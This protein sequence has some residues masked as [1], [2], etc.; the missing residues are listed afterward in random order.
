MRMVKCWNQVTQ[1]GGTCPIAGNIQGQVGWALSSLVELE[2]SLLIAGGLDYMT[3]KGPFQPRLFY[4]SMI[5][6]S[7]KL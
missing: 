7:K 6:D 5:L 2:V 3:F 1:R 4:A